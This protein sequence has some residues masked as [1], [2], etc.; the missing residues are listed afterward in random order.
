ME[1]FIHYGFKSTVFNHV[2]HRHDGSDPTKQTNYF[3][4]KS[5]LFIK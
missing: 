1:R 5:D 3:L 4:Y 2:Y